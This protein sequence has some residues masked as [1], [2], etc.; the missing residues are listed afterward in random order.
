MPKPYF[1]KLEPWDIFIQVLLASGKK[2]K[3]TYSVFHLLTLALHTLQGPVTC[4]A[5]LPVP[6]SLP[7]FLE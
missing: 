2:K 4:L 1:S 7:S 5:P 6:S 3:V